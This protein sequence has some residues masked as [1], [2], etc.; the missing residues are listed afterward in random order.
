MNLSFN[1]C[2]FPRR[3]LTLG[4][5]FQSCI[6]YLYDTGEAFI[7]YLLIADFILSHSH[8]QMRG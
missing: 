3:V 6:A 1:F 8:T 7:V 2:C 5:L 4:G